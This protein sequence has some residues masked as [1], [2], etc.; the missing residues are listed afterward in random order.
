MLREQSQLRGATFTCISTVPTPL[1]LNHLKSHN[2]TRE[3]KL[4]IPLAAGET[5]AQCEDIL[6]R[7]TPPAVTEWHQNRAWLLT[8][9]LHHLCPLD[10]AQGHKCQEERDQSEGKQT[11]Q[12]RRCRKGFKL[13]DWTTEAHQGLGLF[14]RTCG[15]SPT[16]TTQHWMYQELNEVS[17]HSYSD[18]ILKTPLGSKC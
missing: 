17:S 12:G 7:P 14:F 6:G 9:G 2:K 13:A 18:S 15:Q 4:A 16:P 10:R 1:V 3:N 8:A 11:D 5:V